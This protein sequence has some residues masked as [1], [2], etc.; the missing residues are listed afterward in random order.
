MKKSYMTPCMKELDYVAEEC[1]SVS[2]GQDN[3]FQPDL[4]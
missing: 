4:T 1:I 3:E 2:D